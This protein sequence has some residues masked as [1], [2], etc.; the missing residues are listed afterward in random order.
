MTKAA[1]IVLAAFVLAA[2]AVRA[3]PVCDEPIDPNPAAELEQSMFCNPIDPPLESVQ[4]Q[5]PD[6]LMQRL[7]RYAQLTMKHRLSGLAS[8]YSTF[9]DGRKTANGEVY[10]NRRYSAAHL[11]LP[12]GSW[13]EVT[14]RAT[15]KKIRLRVNDRGPYARKFVLDLSQ[16]AARFLGVDK[17]EDRY[18]DIRLIA[19]PGEKPLPEDLKI[20][21]IEEIEAAAAQPARQAQRLTGS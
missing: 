10:R 1:S 14:S 13:V 20:P 3:Q 7:M 2:P 11:T 9:F 17:T 21:S 5:Q 6:P 18:V 8:Y 16:A 19:L 4:P 15:G 12:L